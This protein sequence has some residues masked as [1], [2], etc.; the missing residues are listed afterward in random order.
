MLVRN[1]LQSTLFISLVSALDVVKA[2]TIPVGASTTASGFNDY[3]FTANVQLAVPD[4]INL[5][6]TAGNAVS[7]TT[8]NTGTIRFLGSSIVTGDIGKLGNR[9]I[10][11]I[12]MRNN[13]NQQVIFQGAV[14]LEVLETAS[15]PNVDDMRGG[16]I[17][18]Q[19]VNIN[20][21]FA[22]WGA[23][24]VTFKAKTE[25]KTADFGNNV[26]SD[27]VR[28][29]FEALANFDQ[30]ININ[31]NAVVS[32]NGDGTMNQ[33]LIL[34]SNALVNFGDNYFI[35]KDLIFASTQ[36]NAVVF[37]SKVVDV[38][39]ILVNNVSDKIQLGF[40]LGLTEVPGQFVAAA[41][42]EIFPNDKINII[43]PGLP[44]YVF[45][46]NGPVTLV[47]SV[48]GATILAEPELNA[49]YNLF[50]SFDLSV[51]GTNKLLQLTG[52]RV[53]PTGLQNNI[54]GVAEV[55]GN[56][57]TA[58]APDEFIDLGNQLGLYYGTEAQK[59][60]LASAAPLNDNAYGQV[61]ADIQNNTFDLF[62]KRIE[63]QFVHLDN[64]HA[65]YA[66]G[67]TDEQGNGSWVKLFG[68]H[69]KQG[70]RQNINGYNAGV[71][72]IALGVDSK[73]SDTSLLG[74]SFSWATA[75]VNHE[76]ADSHTNIDNYQG[77]LYGSNHQENG[78][79]VNAMLSVAYNQYDVAHNIVINSF[80]RTN[81]GHFH[82]WQY[83][84][85]I[86]SGYHYQLKQDAFEIQPVLSLNYSHAN[87][88]SF[89]EKGSSLTAQKIAYENINT[90][91]AD[92]GIKVL[93]EIKKQQHRFIREAHANMGYDLIGDKQKS[94][95]QYVGFGSAYQLEG[96]SPARAYYNLGL[97]LTTYSNQH[98][99][100]V[101]LGY[102]YFWKQNYHAHAGFLKLKYSWL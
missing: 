36:A 94:T 99:I 9:R 14:N 35:D 1:L 32:F 8:A 38:D 93:D 50:I 96:F 39:N 86:E 27:F 6:N 34:S 77:A 20:L 64:Y 60:A 44:S 33:N 55:L 78:Y 43:N 102:D 24:L 88:N 40:D 62:A 58:N 90:L 19:P 69:I 95:A 42:A 101:S 76:I 15:T 85:R 53:M 29:N 5:N 100:G 12:S 51:D 73:I 68:S 83:A 28:V 82:G 10:N 84:G 16:I 80:N 65:G 61:I 4:G 71:W 91:I 11:Q 17:F 46:A 74:V 57:T 72:G 47:Q 13:V 37:S 7:A 56:I 18:E 66:A 23:G 25:M 67:F 54:A 92:I 79:F 98:G 3:Q 48:T 2:V 59:I 21:G 63:E 26:V 45:G 75:S 22:G 31:K 52:T 30:D 87:F 70:T 41:N 97:S 81:L 89:Q 49:P